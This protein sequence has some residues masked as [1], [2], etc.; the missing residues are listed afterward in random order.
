MIRDDRGRFLKERFWSKPQ[1][2]N[3]Y[4]EWYNEPALEVE[5]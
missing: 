5:P 2:Q 3:F 4:V 1:P